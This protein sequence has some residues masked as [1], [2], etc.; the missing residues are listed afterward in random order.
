MKGK[1][2]CRVG[3]RSKSNSWRVKFLLTQKNFNSMP[4]VYLNSE[5]THTTSV[6][7]HAKLF[8]NLILIDDLVSRLLFLSFAV[9]KSLSNKVIAR[10]L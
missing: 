7:K 3:H 5:R 9:D 4:I 1:V 8:G 2:I 6:N 10:A